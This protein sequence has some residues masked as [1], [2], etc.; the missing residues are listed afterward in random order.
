MQVLLQCYCLSDTDYYVLINYL[1]WCNLVIVTFD[2]VYTLYTVFNFIMTMN[3]LYN[4]VDWR[5]QLQ[6]IA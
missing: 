5:L 4:A 1:H 2:Y 6:Y 3:T